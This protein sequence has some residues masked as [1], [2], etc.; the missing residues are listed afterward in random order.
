MADTNRDEI[1][2][3]ALLHDIGK[4]G[5]PDGVLMKP[6]KLT[7]AEFATID[8]H[9]RVG[10][11]ILFSCCASQRIL[12][13]VKYTPA[14]YNGH[15]PG[16]DRHG[17]ALPFGA[18]LVSILDAFDSMTSE[19]VYRRARSRDE[20]IAE[21]Y[22]FAGTQFDPE[23]VR[24]FCE[25]LTSNQITLTPELT[26]HWLRDLS[27]R[28]A[29]RFWSL[30]VPPASAGQVSVDVLF[31][32]KLLNSM[33]D[34][35][36]FVDTTRRILLWN[37][38]AERLTGISPSSV[39]QQRWS[40]SLIGMRDELGAQMAGD[41]CP[42]RE[43]LDSSVQTLRRLTIRSRQGREL[44]VDAHLVPVI[45]SDGVL[46]GAT[47]LLHDA[48][49]QISLERR[50]QALHQKA[51]RDPLTNVA[52]RAEFDRVLHQFVATHRERQ[53]PCSLIICDVDHF[54][55][56][57]DTYGHPAGDE[58]LVSFAAL[59]QR[60]REPADLVAR[61]G[62]EEFVLLFADCGNAAAA[63]RANAIREE[64]SQLSHASLGNRPI[65]AS[66]GVTQI[67]AG[68]TPMTMLRR[69]DRALLQAK[70]QGRNRV[71]QLGHGSPHPLVSQPT[72]GWLDWLPWPERFDLVEATLVT[73]L[74]PAQVLTLLRGF[75]SDHHAEILT[76][77]NHH[78]LLELVSPPAT[79]SRRSSDR[80][81]TLLVDL[82]FAAHR[83]AP[84]SGHHASGQGTLIHVNIH[85]ARLRE[86]RRNRSRAA[87]RQLLASLQSYFSAQECDKSAGDFHLAESSPLLSRFLSQF[88]TTGRHE[89]P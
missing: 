22:A 50:V 33:H 31:H 60:A 26:R 84:E 11:E 79:S 13:I 51:T 85:P 25:L 77:D 66:F 20:A 80:P 73:P 75:I 34:A 21:L 38:A 76:V 81:L 82:Q 17:Q 6:G 54:K 10:Q 67:Q 87:A 30:L 32:Q 86:R 59:L 9:R 48:S 65:T 41:N 52:N 83:A 19:Q 74:P 36:V 18:R 63:Q 35:V 5:V 27:P 57:N 43:A 47:L 14:W 49:S 88:Q 44:S 4:I 45:G 53:R 29:N 56:V 61:Y 23:L 42:V 62:G 37:R 3:A 8:Q 71:V 69:A 72:A 12:D 68:D 40:P 46:H 24:H 1:E 28:H 78:V 2:V 58:V 55:L 7:R 64:L 16:F 39:L 70:A 89:A 15:R